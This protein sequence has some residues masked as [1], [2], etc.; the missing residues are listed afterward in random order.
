MKG[1][2]AISLAAAIL[3]APSALHAA[4]SESSPTQQT[5]S[6]SPD[7]PAARFNRRFP[8]KTEVG[9]LIGL[10]VLDD[11]DVTLGLV[12]KV[13]RSPDGK[14]KLVISYS[15]WFGWFG[16]PVA[17]PI[18]YVAILARQI[19]SIDMPRNDY[20]TAPT[21]LPGSDKTLAENEVVRIA[22]GRR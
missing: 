14:I 7:T 2:R 21:W 17:I 18:E 9:R 15:K 19:I 12:Q 3:V 1:Y 10:P 11:D 13:V 4:S 5:A 20:E 16:R 22:L 8:Q 6:A